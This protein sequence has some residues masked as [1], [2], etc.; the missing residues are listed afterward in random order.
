[1][2]TNDIMSTPRRNK[3]GAPFGNKNASKGREISDAIWRALCA[4]DWKQLRRGADAVA[5][6]FGN[7][8]PWAVM[9]ALDRREGKVGLSEPIGDGVL[10]ISWITPQSAQVLTVEH[11]AAQQSALVNPADTVSRVPSSRDGE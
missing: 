7:G 5:K 10:Q 6:A 1:M 2:S 11:D 9:L 3:G 4:D 8:E